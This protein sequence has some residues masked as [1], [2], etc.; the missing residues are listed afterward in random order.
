M[1]IQP[2]QSR[3]ATLSDRIF[4][5]ETFD[6]M[7]PQMCRNFLTGMD[8]KLIDSFQTHVVKSAGVT[9]DIEKPTPTMDLRIFGYKPT[10]WNRFG[11]RYLNQE[12]FS[13]LDKLGPLVGTAQSG[14]MFRGDTDHNHGNCIVGL[15]YT[16][17]GRNQVPTITLQSRTAYLF[18]TSALELTLAGLVADYHLE[19]YGVRPRL[20][21]QVALLQFSGIWGF[22]WLSHN[23]PLVQDLFDAGVVVDRLAHNHE[24]TEFAYGQQMSGERTS[25]YKRFSRMMKRSSEVRAGDYIPYI[26]DTWPLDRIASPLELATLQPYGNQED[27]FDGTDEEGP[28]GEG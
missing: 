9:I 2:Y 22:P 20:T 3:S 8:G 13:W 18:P 4:S 11:R 7:Y 24:R 14:Y 6:E 23:M 21:W 1:K 16:Y 15:S 12:F 27:A 10:R 19:H 26:P 5:F 17:Y 25:P 28:D